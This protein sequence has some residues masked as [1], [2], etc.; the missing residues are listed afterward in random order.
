MGYI[1]ELRDRIGNR[2]VILAGVAV[3]VINDE[4]ELLL[5][6][7]R[8]GTWAIPGGFMELGESAED[9]GRRE[10][11][12]ETGLRLGHMRLVGVF[13][14]E[15]HFVKLANGDEYYSVT[16]AFVTNEITGGCLK[17]DGEEGTEVR[18]FPLSELP[19]AF[20]PKIK[21]LILANVEQVIFSE[22]F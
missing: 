3:L 22:M 10:I 8:D 19:A 18:F 17:A 5:Q 1:E 14:G 16:I 11:A 12:E 7:K 4:Y 13:S 6:K 2:P 20:S 21:D 9:T 15:E